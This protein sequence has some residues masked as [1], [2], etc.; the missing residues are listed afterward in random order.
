VSSGL[1]RL[2]RKELLALVV[3]QAQVIEKLEA[4]VTALGERAP[5]LER[6]L[7]R[8]SGNSSM[9]PSTDDLPGR[10]PPPPAGSAGSASAGKRRPGKQLRP[11]EVG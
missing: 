3:S 2:S 8:N 11:N 4:Q 5:E 1:E 6:R 10:A 7:G 9:P